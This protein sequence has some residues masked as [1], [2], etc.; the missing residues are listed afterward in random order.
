MGS[1]TLTVVTGKSFGQENNVLLISLSNFSMPIPVVAVNNKNQSDFAGWQVSIEGEEDPV[2]LELN[3][4]V[5]VNTD[6]DI[7]AV[8][9]NGLVPIYAYGALEQS[10]PDDYVVMI[11]CLK[12]NEVEAMRTRFEAMGITVGNMP[13]DGDFSKTEEGQAP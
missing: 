10:I 13:D 4:P 12:S 7:Q 6:V 5:T 11:G 3:K 8:F 1:A 9:E 2:T